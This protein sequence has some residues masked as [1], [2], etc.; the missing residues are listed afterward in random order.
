MH[1]YS[2]VPMAATKERKKGHTKHHKNHTLHI[3]NNSVFIL[4]TSS[5]CGLL[6]TS[7]TK[8]AAQENMTILLV[9]HRFTFIKHAEHNEL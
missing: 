4:P 6:N 7:G 1:E 3:S 5:N 9:A 2:L 8:Y